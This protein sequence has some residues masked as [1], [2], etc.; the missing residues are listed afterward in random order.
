[1]RVPRVLRW[2]SGFKTK[3]NASPDGLGTMFSEHSRK[4]I[5]SRITAAVRDLVTRFSRATLTTA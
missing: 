1:M 2:S 4:R 3:N 5:D